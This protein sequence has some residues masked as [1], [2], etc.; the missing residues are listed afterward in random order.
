MCVIWPTLILA[1]M[2]TYHSIEE[3]NACPIFPAA[4]RGLEASFQ[5]FLPEARSRTPFVF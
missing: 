2:N 5:G 4:D 3:E 1:D